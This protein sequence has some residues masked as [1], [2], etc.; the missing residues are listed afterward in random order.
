MNLT[1]A[2]CEVCNTPLKGLQRKYCSRKCHNKAGNTRLQNY[3]A[4]QKRALAR[5]HELIMLKGGKCEIC[6]YSKNYAALSF[7]HLDPTQK[8][9]SLDARTLSGSRMEILKDEVSKCQLLCQN[10][11]MEIHYPTLTLGE[12]L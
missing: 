6:G 10:C 9:L 8:E 5:K 3:E 1:I 7:H 4:Q 2:K 12:T 11:H